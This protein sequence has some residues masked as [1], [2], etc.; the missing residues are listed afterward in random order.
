MYDKT[1]AEVPGWFAP[2]HL[3]LGLTYEG[4]KDLSRAEVEFKKYLALAPNAPDQDA[5]KKHITA[6]KGSATPAK[7]GQ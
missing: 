4:L 5:V 6:M 2:V 1:L 3:K 7:S